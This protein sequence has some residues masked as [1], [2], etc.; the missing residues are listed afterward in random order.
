MLRFWNILKLMNVMSF[1]NRIVLFFNLLLP[2]LMLILFGVVFGQ[3][4]IPIPGSATVS[5]AIWLLPGIIVTNIMASGLMG[6]TSAMI[7]WRER[8]IFK[9]IAVTPMP[10]WEI[11]L[12]RVFTQLV[13]LLVQ[14]VIAI[15][16]GE[17]IFNFRFNIQY[18][19]L[20]VLFLLLGS[21]VFLALGQVIASFTSR[22]ELG[23]ITCQ[24][25]YM[26]LTFLTGVML[27]L[28]ILPSGVG[29]FARFTPSYMVADLLRG[30]MIQGNAGA[31]PLANIGGLLIYLVVAVG[32]SAVFFK[33]IR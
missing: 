8:G 2:T 10:L 3:H 18:T 33:T 31:T 21:L 5:Y 12:A 15:I 27:P 22:V 32:I 13:P 17:F 7:T 11:L 9:R 19:P 25:I 4:I 1:R 16:V 23:S 28:Q 6:N 26:V 24:G 14:G 30:A 29:T 20:T